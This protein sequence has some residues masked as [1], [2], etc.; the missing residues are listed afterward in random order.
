SRFR[1]IE[2]LPHSFRPFREN[3]IRVLRRQC[4][5]RENAVD[6]LSRNI[7]MKQ[8]AQRVHEYATWPL[9]IQRLRQPVWMQLNRDA[10]FGVKSA[11]IHAK[12]R[13][14]LNVAMRAP[15]RNLRA[16]GRRVPRR[17]RPFDVRLVAHSA[18][19]SGS[20]LPRSSQTAV[21]SLPQIVSLSPLHMR[22][23]TWASPKS[24]SRRTETRSTTHTPHSRFLRKLGTISDPFVGVGNLR[25]RDAGV[26]RLVWQRGYCGAMLAFALQQS[27]SHR[28]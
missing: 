14:S 6:K 28:V 17:V 19:L 1:S 12:R 16:S 21:R 20:S 18:S 5:H 23:S 11:M 9:P 3:L 7:L 22:N 27:F 24:I 8:I 25:C 15:R 2:V 26:F 10:A 13:R 4:H